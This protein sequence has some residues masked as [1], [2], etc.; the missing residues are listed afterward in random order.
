[1][2]LLTNTLISLWLRH[3]SRA[4]G[5]IVD[6][7]I[8]RHLYIM[9]RR[10]DAGVPGPHTVLRMIVPCATSLCVTSPSFVSHPSFFHVQLSPVFARYFI[11]TAFRIN[12]RQSLTP[13]TNSFLPKDFANAKSHFQ[14]LVH[15]NKFGGCGSSFV[16]YNVT[17]FYDYR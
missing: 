9:L 5:S 1:M 3:C 2:L 6:V 4:L 16:T 13:M 17:V 14:N 11:Q 8:Y 12:D 15:P 10:R 7:L